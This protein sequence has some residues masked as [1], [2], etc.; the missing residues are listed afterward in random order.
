MCRGLIGKKL[1]MSSIFSENGKYLPVTVLQV[2]PCVVTHIKTKASDGYDAIQ[3][4][5]GQKKESRIRKPLKGHLEKSGVK[6]VALLKEVEVD[7]IEDYNLGQVIRAD[8]FKVGEKV[9]VTGKTKGRGF[10]GVIKRHGFSGGRKTHGSKSHRIPGSI[11]CSAW[12]SKVIKGKKLPGHYGD[13]R[14]TVKNL[15][16]VDIR[17]EENLILLKGAVPGSKSGFVIVKK[18]KYS[19]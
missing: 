4:G 19:K 11:G 13:A 3:L 8:L 6:S 12:P 1:G 7:N 17:P 14:K 9:D 10:Q 16:I 18:T 2:G 5:F 15:E